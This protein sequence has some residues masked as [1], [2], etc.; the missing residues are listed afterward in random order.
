MERAL[1]NKHDSVDLKHLDVV[2]AGR[3]ESCSDAVEGSEN[4]VV[5]H[6]LTCEGVVR[7]SVVK[8]GF[9]EGVARAVETTGLFLSATENSGGALTGLPMT[10]VIPAK[11]GAALAGAI[12]GLSTVQ[13]VEYRGISKLPF[14][15]VP[16]LSYSLA[17]V[18]G[19][20]VVEEVSAENKAEAKHD[21]NHT[22][23]LYRVTGTGLL[24]VAL[25]EVEG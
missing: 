16:T 11:L 23:Y 12:P 17:L 15:A 13:F 20:E 1:K 22:T 8:V 10:S 19:A 14:P 2:R 21:E 3:R 7:I 18:E 24:P 4:W 5:P 6:N 9:A 25:V